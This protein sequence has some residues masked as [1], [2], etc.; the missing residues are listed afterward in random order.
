MVATAHLDN[1]HDLAKLA[2]DAYVSKPDNV[3][4]EKGNRVGTDGNSVKDSF[5]ST[6]LRIVTPTPFSRTVMVIT[7]TPEETQYSLCRHR[8]HQ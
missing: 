5:T 4:D 7:S 2:V 1:D 6:V 3:I 8:A